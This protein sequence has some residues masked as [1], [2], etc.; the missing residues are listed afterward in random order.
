VSDAVSTPE[1]IHVEPVSRWLVEH[2]SGSTAPFTFDLIAGGRSNLTFK[3]TD[4]A[5]LSC[6]RRRPISVRP[7]DRKVGGPFPRPD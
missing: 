2:V 4:A 6:G 5:A 1:S 3:V 7:F